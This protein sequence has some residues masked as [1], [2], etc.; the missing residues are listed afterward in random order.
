MSH[1]PTVD[2]AVLRG[3]VTFAVAL[4]ESFAL[5]VTWYIRLA[6]WH[7]YKKMASVDCEHYSL[8]THGS[9]K[10]TLFW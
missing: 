5:N 10:Y 7:R 2:V 3:P 9:F 8:S 4:P 6:S 1:R